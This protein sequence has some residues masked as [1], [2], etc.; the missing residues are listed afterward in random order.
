MLLE[1]SYNGLLHCRGT[2][3][4]MDQ[5]TFYFTIGNA[6]LEYSY[7]G[8]LRCC[9]AVFWVDQATFYFTIDKHFSLFAL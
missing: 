3:L 5:V 7:N 9:G 1:Y 4:W 8:L 6:L 2:E